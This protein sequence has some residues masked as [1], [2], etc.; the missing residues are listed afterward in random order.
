M[1]LHYDRHRHLDRIETCIASRRVLAAIT[2]AVPS[3]SSFD[4][5]EYHSQAADDMS[6]LN[7]ICAE[8]RAL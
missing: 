7:L 4:R 2:P 8:G 6:D 5:D 1:H 3:L